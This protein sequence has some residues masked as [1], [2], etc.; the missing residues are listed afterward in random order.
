MMPTSTT[1]Q[2]MEPA[3]NTV[4]VCTGRSVPHA[5]GVRYENVSAHASISP[6]TDGDGL[7]PSAPHS[8]AMVIVY[9]WVVGLLRHRTPVYEM[10][11]PSVEFSVSY[12]DHT[13]P[14][15]GT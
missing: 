13:P 7:S 3:P 4:F 8:S 12:R 6:E 1:K 2:K 9:G 5:A 10:R 14:S 15:G 11:T